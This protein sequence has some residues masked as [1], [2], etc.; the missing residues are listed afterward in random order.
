[1]RREG[2]SEGGKLTELVVEDDGTTGRKAAI[3]HTGDQ[4]LVIVVHI[5]SGHSADPGSPVLLYP[6]SDMYTVSGTPQRVYRRS[7]NGEQR[8]VR[9]HPT[10]R[11]WSCSG[12]QRSA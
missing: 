5:L 6:V 9:Y 4:T 11:W 7:C 12:R 8:D 1:M 3:L 10:K 2:S